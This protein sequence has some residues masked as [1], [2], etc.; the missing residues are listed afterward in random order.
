MANFKKPR[1]N[2]NRFVRNGWAG[3]VWGGRSVGRLRC[4][5]P[6]L[7]AEEVA[8]REQR[9]HGRCPSGCGSAAQLGGWGIG[10]FLKR[11]SDLGAQAL[12]CQSLLPSSDQGSFEALASPHRGRFHRQRVSLCV[13]C[14]GGG[15]GLSASQGREF[16]SLLRWML[17]GVLWLSGAAVG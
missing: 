10:W 7:P 17:T 1:D 9:R 14:T 16:P 13:M 8:V 2:C 11:P 4:S 5:A 6:Q 15:D 12:C 3:A